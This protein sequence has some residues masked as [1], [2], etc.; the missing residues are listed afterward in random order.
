M[1]GNEGALKSC[2]AAMAGADSFF[3]EEGQEPDAIRGLI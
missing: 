2:S 1:A 3:Q